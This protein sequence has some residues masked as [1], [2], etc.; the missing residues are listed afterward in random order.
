MSPA[1]TPQ[2]PRSKQNFTRKVCLCLEV[3]NVTK[4]STCIQ[5]FPKA[6]HKPKPK[7]R[8][9]PPDAQDWD[10]LDTPEPDLQRFIDQ[11]H[12]GDFIATDDDIGF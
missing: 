9:K 6:K 1:T 3:A 11:Q 12:H 4:P 5:G 8:P 2:T 10:S 7:P